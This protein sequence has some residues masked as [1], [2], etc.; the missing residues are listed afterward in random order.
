MTL[1][2]ITYGDGTKEEGEYFDVVSAAKA[3]DTAVSIAK[4]RLCDNNTVGW[5]CI[6][7]HSHQGEHFSKTHSW[8][9]VAQDSM[10]THTVQVKRIR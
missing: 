4:V 10:N 7:K 2:E 8:K 3:H 1:Y 5:S 9:I 6:L